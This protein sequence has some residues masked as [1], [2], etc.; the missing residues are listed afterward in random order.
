MRRS[1]EQGFSPPNLIKCLEPD[2]EQSWIISGQR[3]LPQVPAGDWVLRQELTSFE[4]Q[5]WNTCPSKFGASIP[6]LWACSSSAP[7]YSCANQ[8]TKVMQCISPE[9][10]R[11]WWIPLN[12]KPKKIIFFQILVPISRNPSLWIAQ[13]PSTPK[14][15]YLL[16]SVM[17]CP[18]DTTFHTKRSRAMR[19]K[20]SHT[21][22][23]I[24]VIGGEKE[25]KDFGRYYSASDNEGRGW[26]IDWKARRVDRKR[27]QKQGKNSISW[28]GRITWSS[29]RSDE[30]KNKA[31]QSEK[32]E[33]DNEV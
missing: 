22:C 1:L 12:Y 24:C 23:A 30:Q 19:P 25:A 21:G 3:F 10:K 5:A 29:S 7:V 32:R 11:N 18:T 16:C 14:L 20:S 28:W 4:G 9:N 26:V 33:R 17:S 8:P 27:K 13:P 6:N 2:L 15:Y 31:R